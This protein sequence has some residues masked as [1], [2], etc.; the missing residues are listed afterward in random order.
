MTID[1][2]LAAGPGTAQARIYVDA[3][4]RWIVSDPGRF[5]ILADVL[6]RALDDPSVPGIWRGDVRSLMVRMGWSPASS[7]MFLLDHNLWPALARY[8]RALYPALRRK[9]H[10]R[11][12]A[13]DMLLLPPVPPGCLT[14]RHW[15]QRAGQWLGRGDWQ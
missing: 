15:P 14:A 11:R 1:E 8:L 7:A 12:S 6:H 2:L 4:H 3:A 13:V 9:L 10:V 5:R